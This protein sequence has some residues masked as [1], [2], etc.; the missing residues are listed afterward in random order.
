M[1][2]VESNN[3]IFRHAEVEDKY[4]RDYSIAAVDFHE[5]YNVG[6]YLN[7]DLALVHTDAD[8]ALNEHVAPICLPPANYIYR[9][10]KLLGQMLNE[11][12]V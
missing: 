12:I 7:N 4:E 3:D 6:P 9:W 11:N 2:T 10:E 1:V 8:V 5:S